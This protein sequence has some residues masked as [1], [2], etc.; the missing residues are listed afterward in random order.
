V[1]R[2]AWLDCSSGVSG[3]MLLGALTDLGAVDVAALAEQLGL[4]GRFGAD[5]TSRG[6]ISATQVEVVPDDDQPHRRLPDVLRLVD[7]AA[8]AAAARQR[9]VAVFRRLAQAEGRV[10]GL[11][12]ET[13]EFH[14]VGAV[15]AIV[16]VLGVCVGL[17]ALAVD[18][19]VVGPIRLGRGQV[20]TRHGVLP[21]PGPAVL[22]LLKEADLVV[23]G[24]PVA[25]ELAT[26]TGIALLAEWATR[27]GP[28]PLMRVTGVGV[29]A[30]SRDLAEQPNVLRLV[31]GEPAD[32]AGDGW[33]VLEANVDDL[34]PRIWPVVIERLLD[35]GAADAWL[36]PIVM[37]K[38]RP[39]HTVSTLCPATVVEAVRL[40]L[41]AETSTIG[42]R[43]T[44][45]GK[46]ALDREWVQTDVGGQQVRVKVARI[47]RDVVNVSPEF[48]DVVRAATALDR[49]VKSVLAAATAA[50][51]QLLAP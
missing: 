39:A 10:H 36:T 22:E 32:A 23:E 5:R 25:R 41:F 6:G 14:E 42:V 1:N 48:D 16:D 47:N 33:L 18:Q 30:G 20:T 45:V 26:P 44:P 40:V 19:L 49:P 50:A 21:V 35:A 4:T 9:A 28:M 38:G 27:P 31:V 17:H 8:V 15:D 12:P 51:H 29:G 34:D 11:D 3:D 13:V 7:S 37:K 46:H 2:L 24:G 43:A